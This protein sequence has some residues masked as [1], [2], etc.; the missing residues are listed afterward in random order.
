[1]RGRVRDMLE[2]CQDLGSEKALSVVELRSRGQNH[3][4]VLTS[5][6]M[7]RFYEVFCRRRDGNRVS[8]KVGLYY[9]CRRSAKLARKPKHLFYA[10]ALVSICRTCPHY[11]HHFLSQIIVQYAIAGMRHAVRV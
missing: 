1:M 2:S 10:K 7:S 8:E 3:R 9:G 5:A 6:P 11:G 4:N